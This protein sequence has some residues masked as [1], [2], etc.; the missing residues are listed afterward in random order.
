MED[1][2]ALIDVEIVFFEALKETKFLLPHQEMIEKSEVKRS[3]ASFLDI[4]SSC[5]FGCLLKDVEQ[6]R[7]VSTAWEW[8]GQ[9]VKKRRSLMN[10]WKTVGDR[11]EHHY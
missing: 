7:V 1:F 10:N 6:C 9:F 11:T 4:S 3:E 5:G 8:T 2:V